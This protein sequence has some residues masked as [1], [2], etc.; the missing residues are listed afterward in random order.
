MDQNERMAWDA[1]R[2]YWLERQEIVKLEKEYWKLKLKILEEANT[3][4][5][6]R[7]VGE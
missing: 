1:M 3:A 2:G 4:D 5:K 7:V 6:N